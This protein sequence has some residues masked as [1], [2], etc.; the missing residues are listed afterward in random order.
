[1]GLLDASYSA[2]NTKKPRKSDRILPATELN[3]RGLLDAATNVPVAG[4][5]L[6]GVLA[7][8][9]AAKGDY[10][11]AAMNALGVLP[12]V[13]GTFIGK[14]AKTWDKSKEADAMSRLAKGED[15]AK[16]WKE[17]GYG[18]AP[19]DKAARSEIDDSAASAVYSGRS[20]FDLWKEMSKQDNSIRNIQDFVNKYP[21]S[22]LTAEANKG[23]TVIPAYNNLVVD[24]P[25][26]AKPIRDFLKHD[27]LYASYPVTGDIKAAQ[28]PGLASMV[29]GGNASFSPDSNIITYSKINSPDGFKSST[30]HETQHKIQD[31][32]GWAQGGSPSDM[33]D[34][35]LQMLRRDVASGAIPSTEMA[36]DMLPMAQQ[37]AYQRLAGEAEARLTQARINL[38]P[39]QRLAQYPYDPEY[40]KQATGVDINNLIVRGLLE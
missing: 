30:I 36:M 39:E 29:G 26:L 24:D 18:K 8:Y 32:E 31:L 19:W 16:V 6:S 1:M 17:T 20:A 9:D 10:G 40:F 11:S 33:R 4:D 13:S 35:A 28:K 3:A 27:S 22:P 37:N 25:A 34:E 2:V 14:G 21:T 12:F 7:A 38:S 23:A 5:A 15:A